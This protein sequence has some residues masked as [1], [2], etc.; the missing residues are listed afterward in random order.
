MNIDLLK[1]CMMPY[2]TSMMTKMIKNDESDMSDEV[3]KSLLLCFSAS[4]QLL[5]PLLFD[6]SIEV[7]PLEGILTFSEENTNIIKWLLTDL[8]ENPVKKSSEAVEALT[9][10]AKSYPRIYIDY[11][12]NF[13]DYINIVFSINENKRCVGTLKLFETWVSSLNSNNNKHKD[14]SPE[15]FDNESDEESKLVIKEGETA[16]PEP[17]SSSI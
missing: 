12:D 1:S 16:F 11:W 10:L 6:K 7:S 17:H 15:Q 5:C 2:I 4:S 8:H 9:N 13:K 3:H 14:I